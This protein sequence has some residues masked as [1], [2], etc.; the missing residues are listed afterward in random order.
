MSKSV[1]P[2]NIDFWL[3]TEKY[4]DYVEDYDPSKNE[5]LVFSIDMI[6]LASVRKA[7]SNFVRIL[8]RRSIPVY[9]TSEGQSYNVE[10]KQIFISSEINNK[11]DF[12]VAVGLALHEGAHSIESDFDV[13][14]TMWANI[15][16]S[17][18]TASDSKN[19]RRQSLEKFIHTMW[20]VIEDRY[21]D[22]Y[23]FNRSPGY[24]GYYVAL[25]DR[26]CNSPEVDCYLQGE[27]FRYP[28][29]ASY[30]FRIIYLTNINT[31]LLALP[32]LED[33]AREIDLSNISRLT[34]TR[35][36]IECAFKVT[37]IVLDALDRQPDQPEGP[38]GQGKKAK[39][40][41][42]GLA[43]PSDYFDFGDDDESEEEKDDNGAGGSGDDMGTKMVNEISDILSGRD[44][45]PTKIDEND[46][47][48]NKISDEEVDD[49]IRKQ[50]KDILKKHRQFVTGQI[51]K[52]MVTDAQKAL[53]DLIEKHG[54][55]L[56]QVKLPEV[57][58]GHEGCLKVDC[59]V[60]EKM[61]KELIMLGSDVFPLSAVMKLGS[62]EDPKPPE[63]VA[64]A[65]QK[66]I[67]LGTKLGRKLQIR[68]E[69]NTRR[70]VRKKHGKINKRLLHSAAFGAEDLFFKIHEEYHND[71]SLHITVDASSSMSYGNKW[72]RTMTA[73]VAICKAASMVDNIHVTVSFRST[74]SS[75]GS[76]LPYVIMAYDSR[77]DK[78]AKVRNLFPYL[79]PNGMTPEGLAFGAIMGLFEGISP[80]EQ[81]R[82][83]LNL[84]DGEPCFMVPVPA[85]GMEV[86]YI[87]ET[88]VMHTKSQVD[89]IRR[90]GVEILSYF[91]SD[92]DMSEVLT[93]DPESYHA[94]LQKNFRKMYGKN[95]EFID[96]E[97]VV[98][99][100]KT[101]NELFL[102]KVNE[103]SA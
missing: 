46:N 33:I 12:D 73:V 52:K 56:V 92:N 74:Q 43:S 49:D 102:M 39:G 17:I 10:G 62:G 30:E 67:S 94:K 18:L 70:D 13:G 4:G 53:L 68:A 101:M 3:D 99:L 20:N 2:S 28:S 32:R 14:K 5:S 57:H 64:A 7:I 61:T 29:L 63:Y 100:A 58:S 34:T 21:I 50:V 38:S 76:H 36:R 9:F 19:I 79:V 31:D 51:P 78:F 93:A 11:S 81:D 91:I 16:K 98:D 89:K 88:G 59:I 27:L 103:K 83:F 47:A 86:Q 95:A 1:G 96:I 66:G 75:N 24:R 15:P 37:E 44:Q 72:I 8:T 60:V 90:N 41:K 55:T 85:T 82:Y 80:D 97:N 54:I 23:V 71:V 69:S 26:Y 22:N 42:G 6:R 77:K 84:S 87:N 25:Y 45:D 65:V 40:K 48:V 35:D